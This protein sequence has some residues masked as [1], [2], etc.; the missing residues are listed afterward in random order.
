MQMMA[1]RSR[2]PRRFGLRRDES[3]A[4]AVLGAP[5]GM[6][7][8]D[9]RRSGVFQHLGAYVA[10]M[11]ARRCD[12]ARLGAPISPECSPP[13]APGCEAMSQAGK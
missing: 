2:A 6:A 13:P 3:V 5:L 12:M 8:D 9:E 10:R 4:L 7:D 1:L 11:R